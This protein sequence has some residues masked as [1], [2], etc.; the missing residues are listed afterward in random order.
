MHWRWDAARDSFVH[1]VSINVVIIVIAVPSS[2]L[3]LSMNRLFISSGCST[4]FLGVRVHVQLYGELQA[5][6]DLRQHMGEH[7]RC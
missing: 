3:V 1:L 7:R 6:V 5:I 4:A 2:V